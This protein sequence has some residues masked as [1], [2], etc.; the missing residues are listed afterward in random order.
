[1]AIS[2][3]N[4]TKINK[5]NR[6]SQNVSLGTVIQTIQSGSA[7]LN[8]YIRSSGSK[9]IDVADSSASTVTILTGLTSLKGQL[10]QVTSSTGSIILT[11]SIVNSGSNLTIYCGSAVGATPRAVTLGDKAFWMVW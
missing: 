2:N 3:A 8:G 5:M 7:T 10:V 11:G 6:A 4:A 1:M 9:S